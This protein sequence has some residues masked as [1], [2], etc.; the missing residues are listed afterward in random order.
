MGPIILIRHAQSEHH[1]KGM[2]GGWT[3]TDLTELGQRQAQCLASR[4]KR[5]IAAV[6]CHVCC[7]D[8]RRALQTADIIGRTIGVTP[9][10]VP[11]LR[12]FNNGIAAGMSEEEARQYARELTSPALDWQP[13]PEAETWRQFYLRVS[14][15]MD[16]LAR[17]QEELLL[18]VTHGG[19][20]IN[21]VAWWLQLEIESIVSLDASPASISVMRMNEWN[22][23]TIERLN[24]TAHLYAAGLSDEMRL[25]P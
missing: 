13:Y 15:C 11:E 14:A 6:A 20:I 22:E 1:V 18:L 16:R 12:E 25:H 24:D 10:P 23:R 21:I 7:S 19:T 4:L 2:T 5:E 9:E 8:L 3:D 17:D